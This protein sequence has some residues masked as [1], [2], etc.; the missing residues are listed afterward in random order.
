MKT[1]ICSD[2]T[3]TL[4]PVTTKMFDKV[5]AKSYELP[6]PYCDSPIAGAQEYVS[7]KVQY[8]KDRDDSWQEPWTTMTYKLGDCEDI[9]LAKL[10]MLKSCKVEGVHFVLGKAGDE[11]HALLYVESGEVLD[12]RYPQL[13]T[14]ELFVPSPGW[15]LPLLSFSGGKNYIW[16]V[17]PHIR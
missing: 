4:V 13:L 3:Y 10:A 8:L 7:N 5:T 16:G 12:C 9:A 17:T 1:V 6:S 14:Q 2:R 11:D 15:F